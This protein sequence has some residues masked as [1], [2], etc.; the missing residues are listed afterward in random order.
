[1]EERTLIAS[2]LELYTIQGQGL[3]FDQI[4]QRQ[5]ENNTVLWISQE[6]EINSDRTGVEKEI[7]E[8][9]VKQVF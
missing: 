5:M 7:R 1:M 4:Q 9:L 3:C 8:D 2:Y 6:G